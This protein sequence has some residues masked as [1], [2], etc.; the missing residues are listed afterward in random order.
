MTEPA[1]QPA[2]AQAMEP[3]PTA[4]PTPIDH[5]LLEVL[6]SSE[7]QV[8][9]NGQP[10]NANEEEESEDEEEDEAA[11]GDY[12]LSCSGYLR[13][14]LRSLLPPLCWGLAAACCWAVAIWCA[15]QLGRVRAP[16][17]QLLFAAGAPL[18]LIACTGLLLRHFQHGNVAPALRYHWRP[19]LFSAALLCASCQLG[20]RAAQRLP[21]TADAACIFFSYAGVMSLPLCFVLQTACTKY[22]LL[23][24]AVTIANLGL[25]ARPAFLRSALLAASASNITAVAEAPLPPTPPL[26][27][28]GCATAA[29]LLA[30]AVTV[31]YWKLGGVSSLPLLALTAGL[32]CASSLALQP[33]LLA[34]P[35][36]LPPLK[37]ADAPLLLAGVGGLA[38]G[39]P[40]LLHWLRNERSRLFQLGWSSTASLVQLAGF[41]VAGQ[42]PDSISLIAAALVQAATALVTLGQLRHESWLQY[43]EDSRCKYSRLTILPDTPFHHGGNGALVGNEAGNGSAMAETSFNSVTVRRQSDSSMGPNRD[44][45]F[46]EVSLAETGGQLVNDAETA[47]GA[48]GTWKPL[49]LN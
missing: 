17:H 48:D 24:A 22:G 19:M 32:L 16:S 18:C 14:K 28:A 13:R 34:R 35:L 2:Q 11:M 5:Q 41:L 21:V 20:L 29:V 12:D 4:A 38:T 9:V 30:V 49:K 3:V 31:V 26:E 25:L 46:Q 36:R 10:S 7:A 45:F 39:L 6:P 37:A 44:A 40:M 8:E 47:S 15:G 1:S 43:R 27:F 23:A 33:L 42:R